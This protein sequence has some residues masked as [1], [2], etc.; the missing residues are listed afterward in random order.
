MN[1]QSGRG[2]HGKNDP[3]WFSLSERGA[4]IDRLFALRRTYPTN[5]RVTE[6]ALRL[7]VSDTAATATKDCLFARKAF[8]YSALG[9]LKEKCMT[10]VKADCSR[11]GWFVPFYLHALTHRLP[12]PKRNIVLP[13]APR[14]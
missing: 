5:L 13:A 9:E 8:S 12:Q 6:R 2:E 3:L 1:R 14:A 11:C 7:M 10:G 4:I